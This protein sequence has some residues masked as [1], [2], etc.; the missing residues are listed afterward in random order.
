[1]AWPQY[2]DYRGHACPYPK[3]KEEAVQ[4]GFSKY[5]RPESSPRCPKD[6]CTV[7]YVE[8]DQCIFCF[9]K[10][11]MD[12]MM[13]RPREYATSKGM[14]DRLETD[15]FYTAAPCLN[16][17]HLIGAFKDGRRGCAFCR[18]KDSPRQ[19]AIKAGHIK[20]TPARACS[21]CCKRAPKR[22]DNG[23]CDGC[24]PEGNAPHSPRQQA[25]AAGEAKYL[26]DEP[27]LHCEQLALKR[28]DNGRCDGCYPPKG[29]SKMD[30]ETTVLMDMAPDTVLSRD[31][32]KAMNLSAY[33]TGQQCG[34]GHADW[35]YVSTRQ[36]ITCHRGRS[37]V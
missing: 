23:R 1:M 35:R 27:C 37:K 16:G 12:R 14:C 5:Q 10:E 25:V 4:E 9:A 29:R 7:L 15:F 22:V 32:A 26:P 28:V 21:K 17:A 30:V 13:L 19:E 8:N 33:R 2:K 18:S 34:H 11:E 6:N 36:C 20:Y 3:T 31:L 24:H